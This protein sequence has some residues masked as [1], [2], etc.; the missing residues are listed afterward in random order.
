[1]LVK[2]KIEVHTAWGESVGVLGN[3]ESLGKWEVR[4]KNE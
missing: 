1:M 2:F 4:I 3:C